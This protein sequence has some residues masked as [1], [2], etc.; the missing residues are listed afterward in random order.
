MMT[1]MTRMDLMARHALRCAA[2]WVM[3][4]LLP[5]PA[6]PQPSPFPPFRCTR[7]PARTHTRA[8]AHTYAQQRMRNLSLTL[9]HAHTQLTE[10]GGDA[11]LQAKRAEIQQL[12]DQ[13]AA[14]NV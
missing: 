6:P 3:T 7:A 4:P 12:S 11:F 10:Q 13:I 5:P 9:P 1:R 14:L 2:H 8:H